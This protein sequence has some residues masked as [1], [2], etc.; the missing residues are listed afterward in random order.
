MSHVL[1][2]GDYTYQSVRVHVVCRIRVST[3]A[4]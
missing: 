3:C 4:T 1:H 2:F